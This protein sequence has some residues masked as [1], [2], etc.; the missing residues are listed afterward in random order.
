MIQQAE[1]WT[2]R[3]LEQ[4]GKQ[5]AREGLEWRGL[6]PDR[7]HRLVDAIELQELERIE[8]REQRQLDDE[9]N[10]AFNMALRDLADGKASPE[11]AGRRARRWAGAG[12]PA[13]EKVFAAWV[14]RYTDIYTDAATDGMGW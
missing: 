2:L 5:A 11:M 10:T 8:A 4:F 7:Y 13:T 3:R 12:H 6:V 1:K 9:C 14:L